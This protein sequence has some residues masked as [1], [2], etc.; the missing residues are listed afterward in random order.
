MPPV[1]QVRKAP[2]LIARARRK[3]AF[4]TRLGG[5]LTHILMKPALTIGEVAE[6]AGVTVKTVR[7]Y[8]D[9]GLLPPAGRSEGNYRLYTLGDVVRVG[10]I[11][12][13]REAGFSIGEIRAV[14]ARHLPLAEALRLR[15][16]AVE[17]HIRA[18][19][20]VASALRLALRS[21]PSEDDLRR[22]FSVT[23]L[24]NAARKAAIESRLPP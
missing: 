17:P 5:G 11:R 23:T 2:R 21:D 22:L 12:S 19:R 4:D 13:L 14:L 1:K 18:L 24:S 8:S 16:A 3:K 9:A 20:H 15:R 6:R 10:L 7:F